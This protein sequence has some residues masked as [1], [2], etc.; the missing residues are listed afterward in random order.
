MEGGAW[1][2]TVHGIAKSQTRLSDM[3]LLLLRWHDH[4]VGTPGKY[5]KAV[6]MNSVLYSAHGRNPLRWS[7]GPKPRTHLQGQ[8]LLPQQPENT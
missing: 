7:P 3:L 6:G 4:E 2:A 5:T 1:W 8:S